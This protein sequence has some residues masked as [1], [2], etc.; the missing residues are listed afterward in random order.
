MKKYVHVSHAYVEAS[1]SKS[2]I[3]A[4]KNVGYA[5]R[6]VPQCRKGKEVELFKA[7]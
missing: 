6:S 7:V 2:K 3:S 1:G 5:F 4:T